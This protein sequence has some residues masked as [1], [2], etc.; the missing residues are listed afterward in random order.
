MVFF[1]PNMM[2]YKP[3][4][5][6]VQYG[7]FIFFGISLFVPAKRQVSNYLMALLFAYCLFQTLLNN[8]DPTSRMTL[9]NIFLG[10]V[11]V[12]IIAERVTL[13][14]KQLGWLFIFFAIVNLIWVSLQYFDKDPIFTNMFYDKMKH[15]DIVGFMGARFALGC[16]S[17][18]ISPFIFA[19]SPWFCVLLLPLLYF[20]KASTA[21][22]AFAA[23]FMFQMWFKSRKLFVLL[24]LGLMAVSFIFVKFYDSPGGQ[25]MKRIHVWS[26]GIR[27]LKMKPWFG[28]GLG[29]WESTGFVTI[30][31]NGEPEKWVW[32][33]NDFLQFTFET[34][35]LGLIFLYA[36]L[37]NF[38]RKVVFCD[39]RSQ[40]V[41]AAFIS[42]VIISFFHFPF[43]IGRLAGISLFILAIMEATTSR[44][45]DEKNCMAV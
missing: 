6:F 30:Q 13:D 19:V 16:V 38:F 1:W 17:A 10:L 36:Y 35:F 37:K 9:V 22:I 28:H 21:M 11:T 29:K 20:A 14:F 41:F 3:Q 5:L 44:V 40:V 27:V 39:T 33:H 26:A 25:F 43:H 23:S 12:K 15:V 24:G 31:E 2:A 45:C 34:G 42:L 7:A 32:A 4:E 18:L 8:F